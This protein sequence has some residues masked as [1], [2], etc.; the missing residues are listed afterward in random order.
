MVW[1]VV[2]GV[3]DGERINVLISVVVFLL[4]FV[5][6][7]D[8]PAGEG[9]RTMTGGVG[10]YEC[11]LAVLSSFWCV[12]WTGRSVGGGESELVRDFKDRDPSTW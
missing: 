1:A 6:D 2:G 12:N 7:D 3:V 9:G 5:R 8:G 11:M 10:G 4:D